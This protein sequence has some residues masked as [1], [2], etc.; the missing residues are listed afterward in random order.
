MHSGGSSR[1]SLSHSDE[2]DPN[3]VLRSSVAV[4]TRP[5]AEVRIIIYTVYIIYTFNNQL[6]C[7]YREKE[8]IIMNPPIHTGTL[9]NHIRSN[10]EDNN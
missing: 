5:L 10:K 9:H 3:R 1:S 7:S 8:N 6:Y 4:V 2:D